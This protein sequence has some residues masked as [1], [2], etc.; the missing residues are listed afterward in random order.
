MPD[1]FTS[2]P[3]RTAGDIPC[4]KVKDHSSVCEVHPADRHRTSKPVWS[5]Y[6]PFLPPGEP[7]YKD[8]VTQWREELGYDPITGGDA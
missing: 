2:C 5:P 3:H 8:A 1:P 4:W 6:L 7:F